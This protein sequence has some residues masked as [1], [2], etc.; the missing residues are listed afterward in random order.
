MKLSNT[1]GIR[2]YKNSRAILMKLT[3]RVQMI[4]TQIYVQQRASLLLTQ[5]GK[6]TLLGLNT[7]GL[8]SGLKLQ[9]G[10]TQILTSF[11]GSWSE[12]ITSNVG[13][14]IGRMTLLTRLKS[15]TRTVS[16]LSFI[17]VLLTVTSPS[18]TL[19]VRA[20]LKTRVLGS[21]QVELSLKATALLNFLKARY[22]LSS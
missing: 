17:M 9:T 18:L 20:K 22:S 6:S 11:S 4:M 14:A 3:G 8:H 1:S 13:S 15:L 12:R 21:L 2:H 16:L 10:K 5:K 7:K 19:R